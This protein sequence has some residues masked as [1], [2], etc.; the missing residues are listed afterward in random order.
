MHELEDYQQ[1]LQ[2]WSHSDVLLWQEQD[3]V[4][5]PWRQLS[6][7]AADYQQWSAQLM[8]V[9]VEMTSGFLPTEMLIDT[10]PSTETSRTP[11]PAHQH[12]PGTF[13]QQTSAPV[14]HFAKSAPHRIDD[15]TGP[16]LQQKARKSS[17]TTIKEIAM[18]E[19]A[20]SAHLGQEVRTEQQP[21]SLLADQQV[22]QKSK[23]ALPPIEGSP[24]SSVFRPI[25]GLNN[26][27]N[28][29]QQGETQ[30][31]E[32]AS[33]SD[34]KISR[35]EHHPVESSP[36]DNSSN[37]LYKA[38]ATEQIELN[39]DQP[40]TLPAV[41]ENHSTTSLRTAV[42][43]DELLTELSEKIRREYQRFYGD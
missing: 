27:A 22:E 20:K 43:M 42:E 18:P 2:S 6:Q 4:D 41:G 33:K 23:P 15:M 30:P 34:T 7:R 24:T 16:D 31:Q 11:A 8:N 37:T 25:G 9:Y 10:A 13:S 5:Q 3:L 32:P 17:P 26:F 14:P 21:I 1:T 19:V 38:T 39:H 29:F 36:A 12:L 35:R 40:T 28:A